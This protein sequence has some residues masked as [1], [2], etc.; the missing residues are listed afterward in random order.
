MKRVFI[1]LGSNIG[2]R[3][4]FLRSAVHELERLPETSVH[5]L[6][7]IYETEPV[8]KKD[9][10]FFL[11][12]VVECRTNLDAVVI[13]SECKA[14]EQRIG[15]TTSAR[16]GPREIDLDLLYFGGECITRDELLV[17]H[18]EIAQRKFVLVPMAEVAPEF[19]DPAR[20]CSI[21]QLLDSCMDASTVAKTHQTI[22]RHAVE[23]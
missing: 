15:R 13:H 20:M 17:P 19:V 16:W 3:L 8:G 14:I 7:S 22:H 21:K 12:M 11:N 5:R 6:S 18:P 9:Q 10:P 23:A 1:G 2:D 4:G